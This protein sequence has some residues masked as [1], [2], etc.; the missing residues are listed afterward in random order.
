MDL[1]S[2]Q[3]TKLIQLGL[4]VVT[5][6]TTTLAGAEWTIGKSVLSGM[7][8]N[9]FLF[10]LHFSIPFLFTLT[11]HEFGHYFTARH[12]K[13]A[14]SLPYYIPMWFGFIGMASLGTMGA[15]IRI[16]ETISSRVKYFDVGV[17]G[18]I[19]GFVVALGLL[20]YGFTHLPET[21]YIY[22]IHP[23]YE[24]FGESFEKQMMGLDTLLL[25]RNLD[26]D[27][28]AYETLPDTIHIGRAGAVFFG[29]NILMKLGRTYL[30]PSDR[31]VPSSRELMHYP[32]LLAAYLAFF[33]TALN[34]LPIGQLD[35]G[36]VI[37][38]L[39]GARYHAVIS[40]VIY[41]AFLGYAGLGWVTAADLPD[42]SLEAIAGF[43][44]Q[45]AV[46]IMIVY[47]SAFSM[48]REKRNR[49]LYATIM[50][51]VQFF[52]SSVFQIEGY[53][54]WLLFSVLIGRFIGIDHPQ[55]FDAKPLSLGRKVLGWVALLIFILSFS[56]QPLIV[57][58]L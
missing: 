54:G 27:R 44:V 50:F 56:P 29:D 48:F 9:D 39:F 42:N 12:H 30:A 4:F 36:H 25:K 10:G 26:A 1:N 38:G 51:T 58:G 52:I 34:L 7:T 37:F 8:W 15:F 53:A 20:I 41:T 49:L 3:K 45:I 6:L 55:V 40:R 13:I 16:R 24:V 46:Y 17:S 18:P 2:Q 31:Y 35:G 47:W 22:E 5:I 14:V 23:E 11:I 21:E 19:A 32:V 28:L 33:F 43:L 57:E